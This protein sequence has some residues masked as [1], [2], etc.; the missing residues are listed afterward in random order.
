MY[1]TEGEGDIDVLPSAVNTFWTELAAAHRTGNSADVSAE[2]AIID[3]LTGVLDSVQVSSTD[4]A[5][6]NFTNSDDPMAPASQGL[7]QWR[8][9]GVVGGRVVRGRTF[10][11][12]QCE[13]SSTLG[14]PNE[15]I[16]AIWQDAADGLLASVNAT[17]AI[18]HRPNTAGP[19]SSHEV[20]SA[21]CWRQW[22]V[23]RSRRD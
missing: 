15:A 4:P 3:D 5:P 18:W 7:I 16:V 6:V 21:T 13:I 9:G 22:A 12:A 2:V 17:L 19:G 14:I 11:P 10:L 20:T 23:L 1:F 8:T